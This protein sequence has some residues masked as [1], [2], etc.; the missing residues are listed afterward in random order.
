MNKI[1]EFPKFKEIE[2]T[3]KVL[4]EEITNQFQPYSDFNFSSL[5]AWNIKTKTK[6][7]ELNGNLVIFF[8]DY[9]SNKPILSFT[10][11]NKPAETAEIL[12]NFSHEHKYKDSLR[13]IPEEV[14][15]VLP[16]TNFSVKDDED[17]F[18]YIYPIANLAKMN[19][20]PKSGARKN[21]KQFIKKHQNYLVKLSG[22]Q[23][24]DR[25][26]HLKMFQK[27]AE[28]KDIPNFFELNEYKAFKKFLDLANNKIKVVSL[29]VDNL[30]VG[31]TV[32]EVQTG[33]Y[34]LSHFAKADTKFHKGTNDILNWEEAKLLDAQGFK[35]YNWEQ[36]L[37]LLGLRKSKEKY[38]P[39]FFLKKFT[40]KKKI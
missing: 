1:P 22:I 26:E 31:F 32:Y 16:T 33:D 34:V 19:N 29:C 17:S 14:A 4:I 8:N 2:L 18:D 30:L 40:V 21:I 37:G 39:S 27:W 12:L 35:Y 25:D 3:D 13:L 10:G 9:I 24:V 6:I 36:D 7:S 38:K 5:W 20:W 15:E 23:E 11:L 28:N